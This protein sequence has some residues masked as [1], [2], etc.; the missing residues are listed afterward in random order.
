MNAK[1]KKTEL[2]ISL[3][4]IGYKTADNIEGNYEN[5]ILLMEKDPSF[6]ETI[7]DET[8]AGLTIGFQR[9]YRESKNGKISY[10]LT[11][12]PV[13]GV[14]FYVPL[15]QVAK[16]PEKSE[17]IEI[18]V[19]YINSLSASDYKDLNK[20][21]PA[22]RRVVEKMKKHWAGYKSDCI[23]ALVD[24]AKKIKNQGTPTERKANKNFR[25][26]LEVFFN[27]DGK[28]N[29]GMD[30]KVKLLSSRNDPTADPVMYRMAREA[31]FKIY[32]KK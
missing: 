7:S 24:C 15:D 26:T 25:E 13:D 30:A 31:F 10:Y 17:I 9:K 5:A 6:P 8:R 27:G 1:L 20:N 32:T 19:D 22:K 28:K 16:L 2:S 4:D 23:K 14:K 18:T 3:A 29:G 12:N 11:T 21:D